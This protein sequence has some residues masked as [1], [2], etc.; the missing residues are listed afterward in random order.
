VQR[1]PQPNG[2]FEWTQEPWGRAL[3]CSAIHVPHVFSTSDLLLGATGWDQLARSLDLAPGNVLRPKQVHGTDV[4]IVPSVGLNPGQVCATAADIIMTGSAGFGVAVQSADCVPLLFAD[5]RA[6][7]V[8]AAHAG[9]KGTAARVARTA[10]Q[11]MMSNYGCR[12]ERLVVAIGPSIGPC[13]YR[14]GEELLEKF[15]AD[16]RRWFY[17]TNDGLLLNLW[18]ANLDQLVEAGVKS[19][20]IHSAELCTAMHAEVFHS[21]RRDG[22]AAGRLV[23]A[24]RPA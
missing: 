21:Y 10:V 17:R 3:R 18:K 9:W 23:A 16:G 1:L 5:R 2:A 24:I 8:A 7:S 4:A 19:E 12:P 20:N 14:V 22:A 11:S 6:G 13:C 15:G